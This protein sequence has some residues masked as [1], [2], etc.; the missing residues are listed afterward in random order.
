MTTPA[1]L[2]VLAFGAAT[3]QSAAGPLEV[4]PAVGDTVPRFEALDQSGRLRSLDD[5]KG[6]N[7]LLLVFV[8]SAD[9]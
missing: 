4:G 3:P 2:A 8:R 9:W 6:P 1:V 7:G 5:L